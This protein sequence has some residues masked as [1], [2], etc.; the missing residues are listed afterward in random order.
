MIETLE[1]DEEIG[2]YDLDAIIVKETD[3]YVCFIEEYD[4]AL[5]GYVF[6]RKEDITSRQPEKEASDFHE[7]V[8]KQEKLLDAYPDR[9]KLSFNDLKS[10]FDYLKKQQELVILEGYG[11][12]LNVG[13]IVKVSDEAV[14]I[15]QVTPDGDWE[16]EDDEFE[17]D[18]IAIIR[19]KS[20][21]AEMFKKYAVK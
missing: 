15:R 21:Y 8:I 14:T 10:L 5:N 11:D 19:W 3:E 7:K 4:F 18:E 17:F 1:L 9:D 20:R 16:E 2:A 6:L 13:S 12:Y